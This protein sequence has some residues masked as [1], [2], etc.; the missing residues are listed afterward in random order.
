[1]THATERTCSCHHLLRGQTE[2]PISFIQDQVVEADEEEAAAGEQTHQSEWCGHQ[3]QA[4]REWRQQ[5][6]TH[7]AIQFKIHL[8]HHNLISSYTLSK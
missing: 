3:Q 5:R 4:W 2:E 7:W 6:S 8:K 1:M